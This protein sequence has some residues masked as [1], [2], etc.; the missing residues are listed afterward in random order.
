MI[1]LGIIGHPLGHTLSPKLHGWL[2]EQTGLTG[3]YTAWPTPPEA[4]AARVAEFRLKAAQSQ[5]HGF[6]VT[7]PHKTTIMPLLDAVDPLAQA[8]GAVNTVVIDARQQFYGYNTDAPGFWQSLPQP[9]REALA[10]QTAVL[11]GAGGSARAV[12]AA[13]LKFGQ[14]GRLVLAVRSP[15]A[16]QDT[17]AC[18][19]ALAS[20]LAA[21]KPALQQVDLIPISR[22][23]P[24]VLHSAALLVNTTPVG[25]HPNEDAMSLPEPEALRA[26]KALPAH[27]LVVDLIY[28]P[29]PTRFLVAAAAHGVQT[30]DGLGMLVHQGALALEQWTQT[31][32]NAAK[33]QALLAFLATAL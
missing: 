22:A 1:H 5:L 26:F 8:I 28:M 9:T 13:L 19:Q 12:G 2:L 10:G 16:A 20:A 14:I 7:L 27:A 17:L 30:V 11:L 6:N 21:G 33:R 32:V 24:D 3:A 23:L 29:R 15:E 18:L 31:S 25:M 4:L